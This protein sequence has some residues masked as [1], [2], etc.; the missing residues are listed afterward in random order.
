M[1]LEP[2][3]RH[4]IKI[5]SIAVWKCLKAS[6]ILPV[7]EGL[8]TEMGDADIEESELR[9]L[10]EVAGLECNPQDQILS[11]VRVILVDNKTSGSSVRCIASQSSSARQ[12]LGAKF[13][14]SVLDILLK[15][16]QP[17][18][19]YSFT[20]TGLQLRPDNELAPPI[21]NPRKTPLLKDGSKIIHTR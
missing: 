20:Q 12:D 10:D 18:L 16:G 9:P 2:T 13:R 8:K 17:A 3:F 1:G 15:R 6:S 4:P 11:V 14:G 19:T 7:V 21:E 5:A